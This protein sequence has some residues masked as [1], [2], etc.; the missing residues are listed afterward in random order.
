M[1]WECAIPGKKGVS[2]LI[3]ILAFLNTFE[4]LLLITLLCE[5]IIEK[6]VGNDDDDRNHFFCAIKLFILTIV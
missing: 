2:K 4:G 6:K 1:L 5:K 3:Y